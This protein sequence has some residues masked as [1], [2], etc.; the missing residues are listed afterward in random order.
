MNSKHPSFPPPGPLPA[1]PA[2]SIVRRHVES[3]QSLYSTAQFERSALHID[4]FCTTDQAEQQI[5]SQ[6]E[7]TGEA[8]L[9][10]TFKQ[11]WQAPIG[12][13]NT[14]VEIFVLKGEIKQGGFPC[15]TRS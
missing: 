9:R 6:D 1:N 4:S 5:L 11:G 3:E 8:T 14:D 13:F 15:K 12:H 7:Q 10:V 2:T